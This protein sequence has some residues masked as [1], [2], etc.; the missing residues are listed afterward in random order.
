MSARHLAS[1]ALIFA[2]DQGVFGDVVVKYSGDR[3]LNKRNTA[4]ARPFTTVD[5]GAGYRFGPYEI[6]ADG[7]NLGDKRD[8]VAAS[9]L[10]DAQ[11]YRLFPRS[12]RV[13][14]SLRF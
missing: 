14:A 10:G 11:Y 2:P 8:P 1:G 6:R 12:F 7:R 4:L 3:Y 9:E 13:T 5:V